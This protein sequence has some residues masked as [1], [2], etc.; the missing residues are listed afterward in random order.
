MD[1]NTPDFGN[2]DSRLFH[3]KVLRHDIQQVEEEIENI[4]WKQRDLQAKY[5]HYLRRYVIPLILLAVLLMIAILDFHQRLDVYLKLGKWETTLH[6]RRWIFL[7]CSPLIV[8]FAVVCYG[9]FAKE[10]TIVQD[11]IA[12]VFALRNYRTQERQYEFEL[13]EKKTAL[14]ALKKELWELQQPEET[15]E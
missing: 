9:V 3:E 15:E 12:A 7:V 2:E 11:R 10:G 5:K 1:N 8:Y 4:R 13:K 14:S 6:I